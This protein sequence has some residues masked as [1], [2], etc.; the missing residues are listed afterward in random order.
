MEPHQFVLA[1][2]KKDC[3]LRVLLEVFF[4]ASDAAAVGSVDHHDNKP[5]G[6]LEGFAEGVP[7]VPSERSLIGRKP[8]ITF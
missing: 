3:F 4:A 8:L 7:V 5:L 2:R 6:L 1:A